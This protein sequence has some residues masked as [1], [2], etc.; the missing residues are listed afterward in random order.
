MICR[1][2]YPVLSINW[3]LFCRCRDPDLPT[4]VRLVPAR[5]GGHRCSGLPAVW[6]TRP[7]RCRVQPRARRRWDHPDTRQRDCAPCRAPR[8]GS[9]LS[10]A[11]P[12]SVSEPAAQRP[13]AGP[14]GPAW[15]ARTGLSRNLFRFT[16]G[17]S[18]VRSQPGPQHLCSSNSV[19]ILLPGIRA[20]NSPDGC[21]TRSVSAQVLGRDRRRR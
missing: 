2:I 5:P 13:L 7:V 6:R 18:L 9:N 16:R 20:R 17:R 3:I 8:L 10:A 15:P 1:L 4:I 21:G 12:P 14:A 19:L 11:Y